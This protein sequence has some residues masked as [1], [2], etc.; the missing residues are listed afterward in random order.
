MSWTI[1]HYIKL[2]HQQDRFAKKWTNIHGV[3]HVVYPRSQTPQGPLV[4]IILIKRQIIL[5]WTVNLIKTSSTTTSRL[6]CS[7]RI[8]EDGCISKGWVIADIG[9]LLYIHLILLY[10]IVSVFSPN[11]LIV[12]W[13]MHLTIT[14]LINIVA[15]YLHRARKPHQAPATKDPLLWELVPGICH[16]VL[17]IH[18]PPWSY[19]PK[20]EMFRDTFIPF[21]S[22][23]LSWIM[24][25]SGNLFGIWC[26]VTMIIYVN[27]TPGKATDNRKYILLTS[28][29]LEKKKTYCIWFAQ[30]LVTIK[31]SLDAVDG[32]VPKTQWYGMFRAQQC[33]PMCYKSISGVT[34]SPFANEAGV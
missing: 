8:S 21:G 6:H 24:K 3:R 18:V 2:T 1:A 14:F 27:Y 20:K 7:Q 4:T 16:A 19:L 29:Q 11:G 32:L 12:L 28:S 17:C 25:K 26:N 15:A 22:I 31:S 33:A 34:R 10:F 30:H 23:N 5:I 13:C 9:L